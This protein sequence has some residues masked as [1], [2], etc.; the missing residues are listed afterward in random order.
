MRIILKGK[1]KIII[2]MSSNNNTS[3]NNSKIKNKKRK[4]FKSKNSKPKL[5]SP[6]TKPKI[7]PLN[8][9][10][11]KLKHQKVVV[12]YHRLLKDLSQSDSKETKQKLKKELKQKYDLYQ[13]ASQ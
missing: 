12:E 7:K 13:Q 1:N 9:G 3:N 2:K 8:K 11:G 5:K 4:S 6:I 10:R